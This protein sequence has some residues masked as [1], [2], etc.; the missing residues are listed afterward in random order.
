MIPF[1]GRSSL[2]SPSLLSREDL[3][4]VVL[5]LQ[6][7]GWCQAKAMFA[8][9]S[10][11]Q[12]ETYMNGCLFVGMT[13]VR[14]TLNLTSIY[15]LEKPAVRS[16]PGAPKP[17]KEPDLGIYFVEF[18]DNYPHALIECKRLDPLE[19]PAELRGKYFRDGVDRFVNGWYGDRHDLDF[20]VGYVQSSERQVLGDLE[21]L[22][23]YLRNVGR[24]NESLRET[25]GFGSLGFVAAS[26]HVRRWGGSRIVL[27]HSFVGFDGMSSLA[28]G[29][30]RCWI[31]HAANGRH[32]TTSRS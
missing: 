13:R 23:E 18:G 9:L 28:G 30:L 17:D 24:T 21:D 26:E 31:R 19:N 25:D 32:G 8:D 14:E 16:V 6:F 29:H 7:E 27:L 10:R 20:M 1:D 12:E 2:G 11:S 3:T 4:V 15:I 22:N 5:R